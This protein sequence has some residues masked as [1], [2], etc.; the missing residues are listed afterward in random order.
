M[1]FDARPSIPA[2]AAVLMLFDARPA[3][4]AAGTLP[5][6][7]RGRVRRDLVK[8]PAHSRG[9]RVRSSGADVSSLPLEAAAVPAVGGDGGSG[10]G[11]RAGQGIDAKYGGGLSEARCTFGRKAADGCCVSRVR[12]LRVGHASS[13]RITPH[14]PVSLRDRAGRVG[15][16]ESCLDWF[17]VECVLFGRGWGAESRVLVPVLR[18]SSPR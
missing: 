8:L 6:G 14:R 7:D 16:R 5:G 9:E 10:L 18:L 3:R 15:R 4:T 12:V 17:L 11:R 1:L 2:R 13:H